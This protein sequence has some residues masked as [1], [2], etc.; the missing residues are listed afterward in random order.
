MADDRLRACQA[1]D[2]AEGAPIMM[3]PTHALGGAAALAAWTIVTGSADQTPAWAFAVAAGGALI[4][5]ADNDAG[6]LL[7]RAYLFPLKAMTLP[8]WFGAPH[9]GRTHSI[10]GAG[11]FGLLVLLW[12]LFF[13]LLLGVGPGS[14]TIPIEVMVVSALLGYLSH[15]LLD[16]LNI[17]GIQLLWPFLQEWIYFPPWRA[18]AMVPGRF[19]AGSWWERLAIWIPLV[20]FMGWYVVVYGAAVGIATANDGTLIEI[21]RQ[22]ISWI[23]TAM[24]DG[25]GQ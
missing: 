15:L 10:V 1:R 17:P 3:G 6:S 8:L 25:L 18:S 23:V 21:P 16:L 11:I 2:S 9:R 7:N 22:V 14:A 4:P 20:I 12:T 19:D 24:R 5:D 13:N